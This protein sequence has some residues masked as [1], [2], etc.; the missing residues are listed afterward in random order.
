[1]DY[2]HTLDYLGNQV[3][4]PQD[5]IP[6]GIRRCDDPLLCIPRDLA[7][8][9]GPL[10]K[11]NHYGEWHYFSMIGKEENGDD[12]SL[13]YVVRSTGWCEQ[14]HRP[15]F[16]TLFGYANLTKKKYYKKLCCPYGRSN[17]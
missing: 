5:I 7:L 4:S 11:S 14:I 1:M 12:F 8:H 9:W 17:F 6:K 15:G 13:F 10:Y 3:E 16:Y 2:K